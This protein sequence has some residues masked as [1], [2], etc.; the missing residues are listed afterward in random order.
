MPPVI[1]LPSTKVRITLHSKENDAH[2]IRVILPY[3]LP[4]LHLMSIQEVWKIR[5][6]QGK[7]V[8]LT[9]DSFDL[10]GPCV[11]DFFEVSDV[12]VEDTSPTGK[13]CGN[14]PDGISASEDVIVRFVTDSRARQKGFVMQNQEVNRGK[15]NR[16]PRYVKCSLDMTSDG[17]WSIQICVSTSINFCV[18]Y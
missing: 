10:A 6:P 12:T 7:R 16:V 5:A 17:D 9:F 18:K 3:F 8:K 2:R 13:Y 1:I 11:T 14:F 15:I 4:F